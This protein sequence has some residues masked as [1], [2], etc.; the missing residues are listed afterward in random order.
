LFARFQILHSDNPA[1]FAHQFK[2][3]VA[4]IS[5]FDLSSGLISDCGSIKESLESLRHEYK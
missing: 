2:E 1:V 4:F 5:F 3:D